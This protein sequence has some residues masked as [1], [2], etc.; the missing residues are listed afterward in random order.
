M[1]CSIICGGAPAQILFDA[2][3]MKGLDHTS[4][5]TR[6]IQIGESA[7]KTVALAASVLRSSGVRFWGADLEACHSIT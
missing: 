5:R 2:M 4:K 6:Y 1:W 3:L 7:G